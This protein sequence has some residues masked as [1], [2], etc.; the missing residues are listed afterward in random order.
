MELDVVSLEGRAVF[1]SEF[2][3]LV[4]LWAAFSFFLMFSAIFLLCWRISVGCL[5][6]EVAGSWVDLDLSV[7]WR[8]WDRPLSI[9]VP[10]GQEFCY[11]PKFW[12]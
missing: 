11:G 1:S 6:L 2:M 9:N 3:G 5:A 10:W 12:S 7:V 4:Y 8:F